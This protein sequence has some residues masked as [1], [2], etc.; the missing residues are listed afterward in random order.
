[1]IFQK[2][3]TLTFESIKVKVAEVKKASIVFEV[4]STGHEEDEGGLMEV[5]MWYIEANKH[6]VM[7]DCNG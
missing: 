5:P 6:Q 2:G 7:R 1:M 4:L 3:E